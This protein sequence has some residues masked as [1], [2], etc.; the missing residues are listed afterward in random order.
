MSHALWVWHERNKIRYIVQWVHA[1]LHSPS[2]IFPNVIYIC[3][4]S[5]HWNHSHRA[6]E[7]LQFIIPC[8]HKHHAALP[9]LRVCVWVSNLML[10][11]NKSNQREVIHTTFFFFDCCKYYNLALLPNCPHRIT[12]VGAENYS[13]IVAYRGKERTVILKVEVRNLGWENS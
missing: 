4:A 11:N 2:I 7:N 1:I 5:I 12:A 13:E 8:S 3:W 9:I 6:F 10:T